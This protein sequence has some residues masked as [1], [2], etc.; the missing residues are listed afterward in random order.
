MAAQKPLKDESDK[1]LNTWAVLEEY[2]GQRNQTLVH[3]LCL[4]RTFILG[5][6]R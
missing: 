2:A 5:F 4:I 1:Q 3:Y 6:Q